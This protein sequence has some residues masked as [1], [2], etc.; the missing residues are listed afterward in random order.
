MRIKSKNPITDFYPLTHDS[1]ITHVC[2]RMSSNVCY[3]CWNNNHINISN[4]QYHQYTWKVPQLTWNWKLENLQTQLNTLNS[5]TCASPN[6]CNKA[7]CGRLAAH[8]WVDPRLSRWMQL[9]IEAHINCIA[10]REEAIQMERRC[11]ARLVATLGFVNAREVGKVVLRHLYQE[12]C[13]THSNTT[14]VLL[15][16]LL[17]SILQ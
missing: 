6:V 2:K 13:L 4:L 17:Y 11:R 15:Q 3:L 14:A 16:F 12:S 10:A 9:I 1:Y 8:T 5:L 7:H